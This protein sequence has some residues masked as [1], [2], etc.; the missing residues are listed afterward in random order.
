MTATTSAGRRTRPALVVVPTLLVALAL[1]VTVAPP[2]EAAGTGGIEV[3]PVPAQRDGEAITTFDV[4]V[5]DEG[6][7]AVPYLLRNV[8]DG[9][10]TARVYGARV[11]RSDGNF[12]LDE[13][14][15]SPYLSMPDREVTLQPG[16]VREETFR[17][18]PGPDGPPEDDAYA[19]VV[20][21]VRNGAVV[22]RAN[23]LVYL[24][25]GRRLPLPLLLVLLAGALLG[26]AAV[27]WFA[28]VRRRR[29]PS[30]PDGTTQAG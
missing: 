10:R 28:L 26:A 9:P 2:G 15:S 12:A 18:S 21:E 30:N 8:E 22:Q 23:T 27:G 13:P 6:A 20:V 24:Q 14:G 11:T 3:T 25:A 4:D 7:V 1:V 29:Q 5:P 16:E 19:A 17:V